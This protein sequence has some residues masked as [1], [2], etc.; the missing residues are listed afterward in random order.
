M[1]SKTLVY[2]ADLTYNTTVLSSD[3]FPIG[4]GYVVAYAQQNI[5]DSFSF[6]L[7]K[8]ADKFFDAIDSELPDILA[9]SYFPWNKN[10]SL[11][12]ARYYKQRKPEGAV[13]IGGTFIPSEPEI[14]I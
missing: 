13:V 4:I 2:I 7:F 8:I 10:L 3:T 6:K 11:M 5:P 14:Q 9:M 1:K 12:A